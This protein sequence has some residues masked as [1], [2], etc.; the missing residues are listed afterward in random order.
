M[1]QVN[2]TELSQRLLLLKKLIHYGIEKLM[3][4]SK[5]ELRSMSK[6]LMLPFGADISKEDLITNVSNIMINKE[7]E[8]AD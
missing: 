6:A 5:T 8:S 7:E 2:Q 1:K 4:L 3:S